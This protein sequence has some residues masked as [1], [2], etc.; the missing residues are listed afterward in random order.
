MLF[1]NH[2]HSTNH[3]RTLHTGKNVPFSRPNYF[4]LAAESHLL[5]QMSFRQLRKGI[6]STKRASASC[7][8]TFARPNRLPPTAE[9]HLLGQM[10]F[11]QQRK[12][13]YS[14]KWHLLRGNH[15]IFYLQGLSVAPTMPLAT[16]FLR[17]SAVK[18][19]FFKQTTSAREIFCALSKFG[20]KT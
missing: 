5:D 11:R 18:I 3:H 17:T 15:P 6:C 13:I 16:L 7:G 2:S 8:K 10:S 1:A 9:R 14:T 12:S 19:A 4:P 20:P